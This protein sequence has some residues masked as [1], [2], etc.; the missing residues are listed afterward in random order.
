[1]STN[2]FGRRHHSLIMMP[3]I[4]QK[5][6]KVKLA[7]YKRVSEYLLNGYAVIYAAESDPSKVVQ[8]MSKIV[9]ELVPSDERE[10]ENYISSGALIVLSSDKF[11]SP[12]PVAKPPET[13]KLVSLWQSYVLKAQRRSRPSGVVAIGNPSVFL[14]INKNHRIKLLEYE[15]AVAKEFA[16]PME[17]ICWYSNS[18]TISKL[19]FSELVT[20]I[21]AH[22][23]TIH[24]GWLYRE[25]H[26]YDII[27]Q[28]EEGM[29]R[30]LGEGTTSLIFKTLKLV[31][32]IDPEK[33]ITTQPE[34]FEE[35]LR[36]IMGD[37]I[38]KLLFEILADALRKEASFNRIAQ[39]H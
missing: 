5:H 7:V 18:K 16:K 4:Q 22:H 1:M 8:Q 35:K 37:S 24:D 3:T 2:D 17:A 28:V 32:K 9:A 23:S 26:P 30:I 34:V 6:D 14:E 10:I 13:H 36:K 38:A 12:S 39:M 11:Y 21:T 15:R 29:D 19:S 33:T 20:I 25:W 27:T 31:Y